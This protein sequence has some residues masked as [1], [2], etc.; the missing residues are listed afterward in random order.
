MLMHIR[1]ER[2]AVRRYKATPLAWAVSRSH[3]LAITPIILE[4]PDQAMFYD[5][6][7]MLSGD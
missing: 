5:C 7:A 4:K 2:L 6:T 1:K 3:A